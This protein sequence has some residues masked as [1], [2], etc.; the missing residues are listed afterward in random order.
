M[1]KVSSVIKVI[2]SL[3]CRVAGLICAFVALDFFQNNER[4]TAAVG[5]VIAVALFFL[6]DL[7]KRK[8]EN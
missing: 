2:L 5:M 3:F 8:L 1:K 7:I 4:T 6:P